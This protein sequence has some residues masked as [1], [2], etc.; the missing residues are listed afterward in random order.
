MVNKKSVSKSL[1]SYHYFSI[2]RGAH[3]GPKLNE[4]CTVTGRVMVCQQVVVI[5]TYLHCLFW[6]LPKQ[7]EEEL[8]APQGPQTCQSI[9]IFMKSEVK[10][11]CGLPASK[12][13]LYHGIF[14]RK[15]KKRQK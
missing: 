13:H 2:L 14:T 4:H 1:E 8:G 12:I 9:Y 3:V 7:A 10:L 6:L 5:M 15:E 11:S